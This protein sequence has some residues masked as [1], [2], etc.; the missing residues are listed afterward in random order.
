MYLFFFELFKDNGISNSLSSFLGLLSVSGIIILITIILSYVS[1]NF[2]KKI[3]TQ[4]AKRTSSN[5]DDSLIENKIP[6]LLGYLPPLF[7]L[8]IQIPELLSSFQNLSVVI[9]NILEALAA[10]IGILIIRGVLKSI[11]DQ[12]RNL[13]IL[14]DK[15]LESY[16]QVFMIFIWF[17][18]GIIILS[19]LTGK[20]VGVF[21]TTLG[22]LSAVIL[23]IF[24]DTLLGF[25]ASI[26]ITINDTVRIGDWITMKNYNADG[27]VIAISLSTVKIQNFDKT[28]TTIPTYKLISDSFTNWRGMSDSDGRRIKRAIL[29]KASSIKFL[30][31]AEIKSLKKIDL[32]ADYI[33][34]RNDEIKSHNDLIQTDK[35]ELINGRN[36]TNIGLFRAYIKSYLDNHSKIN[37]KMTVM[38][39]QLSPTPTGIPLEVYAFITDKDWTAYEGIVSDIFDHLLS[40]LPSFDLENFE[41]YSKY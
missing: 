23:L 38:C 1:R 11:T 31:D 19:L 34:R 28:I 5:F 10:F 40:A 8:I 29:V 15:P 41:L 16:L 18:G 22:A 24:K 20:E 35:I 13:S 32:I 2:I 26:Q 3:F 6:S 25:V 4:I 7:F 14:K 12:L 9:L 30:N 37:N 39:R 17:V 36:F 33:K 21:L 27:D